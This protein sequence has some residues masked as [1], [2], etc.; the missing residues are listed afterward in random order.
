MLFGDKK[1]Q[2]ESDQEIQ[3]IL[4]YTLGKKAPAADDLINE[5]F[6]R[7]GGLDEAL[8]AKDKQGNNFMH[9]VDCRFSEM[10]WRPLIKDKNN[11]TLTGIVR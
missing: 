6:D 2:L 11:E 8:K 1:F 5:F 3:Q 10:K 7:N 9:V 4:S